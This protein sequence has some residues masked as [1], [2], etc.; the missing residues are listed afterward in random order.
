VSPAEQLLSPIAS[1][2]GGRVFTVDVVRGRDEGPV[3]L[4]VRYGCVSTSAEDLGAL[5]IEEADV[6]LAVPGGRVAPE[7]VAVASVEQPEPRGGPDVVESTAA[8]D[9]TSPLLPALFFVAAALLVF[10]GIAVSLRKARMSPG[11]D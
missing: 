4:S 3:T 8:E 10:A 7:A 5:F 2:K 9:V 11:R 6:A 1:P